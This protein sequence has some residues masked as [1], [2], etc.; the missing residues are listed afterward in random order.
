MTTVETVTERI[1]KLL[2]DRENDLQKISE[3]K[4]E[5]EQTEAALV[6]ELANAVTA[7]D[8]AKHSKIEDKLQKVRGSISMYDQ[9]Y[10]QLDQEA[11]VSDREYKEVIDQ[12]IQYISDQRKEFEEK[13]PKL[14]SAL[15]VL[16]KEY[17]DNYT[18]AE[19]IIQRWTIE[20]A[21]R[22]RLARLNNG[23]ELCMQIGAIFGRYGKW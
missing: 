15:D 23:G 5:L 3:R 17:T 4:A 19:N 9:R 6:Q 21:K 13:A 14:L 12:L 8:D 1:E 20:I 18:E 11:L 7:L 10:H 16:H 22:E 2:K